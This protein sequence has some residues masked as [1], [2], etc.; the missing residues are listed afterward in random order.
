[1]ALAG[2]PDA[3]KDYLAEVAALCPHS[4]RPVRE[5]AALEFRRENWSAAALLAAAAVRRDPQDRLGWKLLA[6][7]R[8]LSGQ[9]EEALSAWNR[10]GE[11]R[12]DLVQINGFDHTPTRLVYQYLGEEPRTLLTPERLRR[13]QRRIDALP[14]A[15]L[16]RVS[17]RPL[18]GG[19]AQ[20]EVNVVERPA[21]SSPLSVLLQSGV[22]AI[23]ERAIGADVF[24]IASSGESVRLLG[25]WQPNRSHGALSV[26]A[27]RF[28]GLPGIVTAE[29]LTDDQSYRIAPASRESPPVREK[30]NRASLSVAHWWTADTRA[31][32]T[33]AADDWSALGRFGSL[34]GDVGRRLLG[35]HVSV[36]ALGAG[37]WSSGS[38]PFYAAG[39]H[40]SG[41]TRPTPE[42]ARMRLDLSYDY[43]S[44]RAPLALWSGAGTGSARALLLRAHPLVR[45]GVIEGTAFGRELLAASLQAEMPLASLG[46]ARLRAVA[47][48]DAAKVLAPTRGDA[49]FDIGIGLRLQPP[50]WKSALRVDLATPWGTAHPRLSVGWQGEWP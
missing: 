2:R 50:G 38:A 10:I 41:R 46:P 33:V 28:L 21:F 44:T 11:P 15:Q 40:A 16:S 30:R 14:A 49:A 37:W 22:R 7:S 34:A 43:A 3:A 19:T 4:P 24:G 45:D 6:T 1:L 42:R 20:L 9:R 47:F 29:A 26:S 8:F 5:M 48:I 25:Q 23:A 39:V 12:L 36:G 32:A 13:V 27:P 17:Y 18:A 31:A 35:N